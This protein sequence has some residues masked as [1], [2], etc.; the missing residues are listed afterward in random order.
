[1]RCLFAI[2]GM[3]LVVCVLAGCKSSSPT[4]NSPA[5]I[6][7]RSLAS[8]DFSFI[9]VNATNS[10]PDLQTET[11]LLR[12]FI[13]SGLRETGQFANV[14]EINT[15]GATS[16]I[17]ILVSIKQITRVTKDSR[18]WFGGLAGRAQVLVP[19]TISDLGTGKP[20]EVFEV[21]GQSGASA[22]AGT[23]DEAI[24]RAAATVVAE[25]GSLNSQAA[26]ELLRSNQ[27]VP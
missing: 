16:G 3:I 23:T 21:V 12:D 13:L 14:E 26:Q 6:K 18:D 19:V 20:I 15:N 17:K 10:S 4:V 25:I 9:L 8:V 11:S 27:Q 2:I 5:P 7:A 1:M 24:Q 22:R